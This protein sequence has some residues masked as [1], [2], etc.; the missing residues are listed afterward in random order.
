MGFDKLSGQPHHNKNK[1]QIN[2]I[3]RYLF[4]TNFNCMVDENI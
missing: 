1:N 3:P 4:V 2:I